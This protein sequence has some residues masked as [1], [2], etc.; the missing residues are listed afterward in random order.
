M[1][2]LADALDFVSPCLTTV[3]LDLDSPTEPP[4]TPQ[5]CAKMT[6]PPPNSDDAGFSMAKSRSFHLTRSR[7]VVYVKSM[8][9]SGRARPKKRGLIWFNLL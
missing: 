6:L 7:A 4:K 5:R 2:E 3:V 8:A 9:F 1:A